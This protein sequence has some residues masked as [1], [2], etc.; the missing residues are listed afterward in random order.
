MARVI[1]AEQF[2][3][4]DADMLVL[5]DL[6]PIFAALEV[7]PQETILACREG[8]GF[9]FK[10]LEHV[11]TT[12]YGGRTADLQRLLGTVKKEAQ[13]PLVVNDDLFAGSHA[14]WQ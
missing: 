6:R 11:L 14:A 12:A 7:C 4:M 2:L 9:G 1:E 10:N 13:Y 3:C 8:N 5:G